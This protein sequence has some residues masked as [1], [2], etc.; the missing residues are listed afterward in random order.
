MN[1]EGLKPLGTRVLV[2]RSV[3]ET[4]TQGGI[5]LPG[6]RQHETGKPATGVVTA[7]GPG[8]VDEDGKVAPMPVGVGDFVLFFPNDATLLQ[9]ARDDVGDLVVVESGALLVRR[10]GG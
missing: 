4:S 7:V 10:P 1:V 6:N 8:D 2:R 3:L 9:D 5:A